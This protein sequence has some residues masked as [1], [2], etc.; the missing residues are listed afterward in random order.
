MTGSAAH[1]LGDFLKT[2]RAELTPR[3]VGLPDSGA[4]RRVPGLRRE[5][6]ALLAA[7]GTD[8][9]TRL[10]QGRIDV[11][12]PVPAAI[13]RVLKLDDD[14][15][16]YVFEPAG[17]EIG[18]LRRP[19]VQVPSAPRPPRRVRR[20]LGLS[21]AMA[22]AF[23]FGVT[24][25]GSDS[26][27]TAAQSATP[28]SSASSSDS[29]S[30][31]ASSSPGSDQSSSDGTP[32]RVTVGGTVLTGRLFDNATARDLIEKL[33][34]TVEF[35]D[36]L[37]MEKTGPLPEEL[38]TEGMPEGED[39][40]PGDIGYYAPGGDLVFYY[41]DVSYHD[42]ILRIGQ[43]DADMDAIEDQEDG[44]TARVEPTD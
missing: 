7:I 30:A 42:G 44:F 28:A 31:A 33:P 4:P 24:G 8:N 43:F 32:I 13:A 35:S 17:K 41:G 36:H 19:E 12:E 11:S 23:A 37:H 2:R 10:E 1:E 21:L 15:R 27:G 20:G 3:S 25:C 26:E 40:R 16:E 5:E 38:S 29:A 39:P 14:Q 18:R 22:F 9:Y 6:V 34:V